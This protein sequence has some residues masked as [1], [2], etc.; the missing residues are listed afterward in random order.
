[1]GSSVV[2][3]HES[4]R[5]S[6]RYFGGHV[7]GDAELQVFDDALHG[8]EGLLPGGPEV[9]LHRTRQGGKDGLGCLTGVHRLPRVFWGGR[10]LFGVVPLD[11]GEGLLDGH[12]QPGR[13]Y[14]RWS[15][16]RVQSS[17]GDLPQ[18]HLALRLRILRSISASS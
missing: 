14:G 3:K 11:V 1:M 18:S 12:H 7:V 13:R 15:V 10:G 2:E 8:V 9:F 5:S 6:G 16:A 4:V 17:T